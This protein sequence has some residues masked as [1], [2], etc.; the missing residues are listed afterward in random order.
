METMPSARVMGDMVLLPNGNVL[1]INGA[2]EGTAGW[3]LGRNPVLT[4]VIY[5]PNNPIGL[6]FEAQNSS[7]ILRMYHSTAVLLRDGRVLVSGSNPNAYYNFTGVVFP[8]DLTM[9]AFSPDYLHPRLA[10][11]CPTIVSPASHSQ[12]GYGQPLTINFRSEGRINRNLIIVTMVLPPFT[13]H[14]FSMNQR[15]LVLTHENGTQPE[16]TSLGRSNYQVRVT[17]QGSPILAPLGYYLLFMVY[18]GIPSQG[19]WIQI[20]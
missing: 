19:I 13:M 5:R 4:P 11:V 6:R 2:S 18:R 20:K 3:D 7:S 15:L 1:I 14:S 10:R 12:I 8:T 17:T 9:E 16:V